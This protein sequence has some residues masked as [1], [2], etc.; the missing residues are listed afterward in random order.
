MHRSAGSFELLLGPLLFGVLGLWL[1]ARAGTCPFITI[2]LVL[3]AIAGAFCKQYYGF[4]HAMAQA[5]A[6]R[7][8]LVRERAEL[9]RLADD[10]ANRRTETVS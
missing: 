2:G 6:E 8:R 10:A 9:R 7:E 5:A 3:F 4:R 1:D